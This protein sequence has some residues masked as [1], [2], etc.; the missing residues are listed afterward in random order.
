MNKKHGISEEDSIESLW[1]EPVLLPLMRE[2][3]RD[4]G[5]HGNARRLQVQLLCPMSLGAI[6]AMG[7]TVYNCMELPQILPLD[8]LPSH[9]ITLTLG[10]IMM[11]KTVW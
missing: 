7:G 11:S 8:V 10:N 4:G 9:K 1:L 3:S 2:E 5:V 6:G